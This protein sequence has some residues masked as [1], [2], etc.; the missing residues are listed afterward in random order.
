[1]LEYLGQNETAAKIRTAVDA[2][3][4]EGKQLTPDLHGTATTEEYCDAIIAKL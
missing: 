1:M 2:V 3:L 4:S